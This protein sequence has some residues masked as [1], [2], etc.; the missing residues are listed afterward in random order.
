[1]TIAYKR[2]K[3]AIRAEKNRV[4]ENF[5]EPVKFGLLQANWQSKVDGPPIGTLED[6]ICPPEKT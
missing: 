3:K 4:G 1:M 5:I 2:R 6:L